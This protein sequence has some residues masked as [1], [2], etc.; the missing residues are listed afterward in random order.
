[1]ES[2]LFNENKSI[3]LFVFLPNLY[4]HLVTILLHGS[5]THV[6]EVIDLLMEYYHQKKDVSEAH[7]KGLYVKGGR[8]RGRQKEK[9]S[10][11]E[12]KS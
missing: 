7:G 3:I 11:R 8:E 1:M 6:L 5:T 10:S 2:D 9:G 12:K 4:D